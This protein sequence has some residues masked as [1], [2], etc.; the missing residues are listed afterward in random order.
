M[1]VRYYRR[2]EETKFSIH[3]LFSF[4][5]LV[6]FSTPLSIVYSLSWSGYIGSRSRL[7]RLNYWNSPLFSASLSRVPR[8]LPADNPA[9]LHPFTC[10]AHPSVHPITPP[11]VLF[12]DS[13]SYIHVPTQHSRDR[14]RAVGRRTKGRVCSWLPYQL[15]SCQI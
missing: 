1:A 11:S 12:L 7:G 8:S 14:Q 4:I 2:S 3:V 13:S 5:F 10:P 9:H 15:L 6:F